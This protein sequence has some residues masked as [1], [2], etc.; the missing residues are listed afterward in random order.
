MATSLWH[1]DTYPRRA[2]YSSDLIAVDKWQ[3]LALPIGR[4]IFGGF[5]LYAGLH[6]FLNLAELSSYAA[7]R[8]VPMPGPAVA[9]SGALIVL[10][11]LSMLTGYL[12]R[13][14]A[15]CIILFLIGVTPMMHGF[16]REHG[17]ERAADI[18][19]F[20]KNVALIGG[21]FLA[22]AIPTPWP[23][24][25]FHRATPNEVGPPASATRLSPGP[26]PE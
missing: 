15:G 1:G 13:L 18:A 14:G 8:G 4:L 26:A 11:G 22:M 10:G 2:V 6:H 21:A 12:P 7:M 19:N 9:A 23:R 25:G 5:F 16:W 17:P 24:L 3:R 20:T